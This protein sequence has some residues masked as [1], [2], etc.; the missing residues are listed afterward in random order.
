MNKRRI[1][2]KT[3]IVISTLLI[4]GSALYLWQHNS[5]GSKSGTVVTITGKVAGKSNQC[6]NDAG[7]CSIT[8]EN[9]NTI[10]TGCPLSAHNSTCYNDNQQKINI[11]DTIQAT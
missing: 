8:L 2:L 10:I 3:S 5:M 6:A 9:G 7:F 11:G 4:V 1:L